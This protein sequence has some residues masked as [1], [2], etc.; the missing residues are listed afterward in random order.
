MIGLR[1]VQN[2]EPKV[3]LGDYLDS[4]AS[5]CQDASIPIESFRSVLPLLSNRKNKLARLKAITVTL[6]Q[7]DERDKHQLILKKVAFIP[8]RTPLKAAS[9]DRLYDDRNRWRTSLRRPVWN[10][11]YGNAHMV[12][13]DAAGKI[14][15]SLKAEIQDVGGASYG[16]IALELGRVD[17]SPYQKLAFW[18]RGL[19]GGENAT[20]YL[21]DGKKRESVQI[22]DFATVTLDWNRVEI[23][24]DRFRKTV[25]LKS[26]KSI[27]IAWEDEIISRQ[28]VY[29]DDFIFE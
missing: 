19:E 10:E 16:L 6:E 14:G 15:R 7:G 18:I 12:L 27:L 3:A 21:N 28:T 5:E 17:V 8:D 2:R 24:L 9:F 23:P 22:R 4:L 1:D 29:L 26:L 11:T 13:S 25:K 20:V